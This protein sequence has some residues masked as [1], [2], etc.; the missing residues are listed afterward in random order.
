MARLSPDLQTYADEGLSLCRAGDWTKG[1]PVLAALLE[2]KSASDQVPGIVYSFFGYG[3]AR[4]Q[5]N[6]REG[7]KLCEHALKIQYYEAD[8]HWNLA[9]IQAFSGDRLAAFQTISRGLKLDPGHEGLIGSQKEIG[10]R[11]KPMLGFLSR[12]NPLNIW[13]G[14]LRHSKR[15]GNG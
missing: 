1:L 6:T 5:G 7:I 10:V 8:N 11:R 12:D 4:Y 3:V 15:S 14:R 13:L 2:K 9:R